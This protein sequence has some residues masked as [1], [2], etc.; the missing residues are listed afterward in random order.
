[1]LCNWDVPDDLF[2]G[3]RQ[4]FQPQ[5]GIQGIVAQGISH[6]HLY[7]EQRSVRQVNQMNLAFCSETTTR[8]VANIRSA[9]NNMDEE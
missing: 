2:S 4:I 6:S 7:P 5:Q 3:G 9:P 1:M 8:T